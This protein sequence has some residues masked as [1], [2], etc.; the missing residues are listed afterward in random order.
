MKERGE[1]SWV[2]EEKSGEVEGG[3]KTKR[4]RRQEGVGPLDEYI[5]D[6]EV[7]GLGDTLRPL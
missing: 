6:V 2:E 1:G 5:R 3:K 7:Q 4:K